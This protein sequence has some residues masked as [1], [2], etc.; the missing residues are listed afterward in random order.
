MFKEVGK[1]LG[2]LQIKNSK[3]KA[4][5]K[6][7]KEKWEKHFCEL[8]EKYLELDNKHSYS[9]L[10]NKQLS[11]ILAEIKEIAKEQIPYLNIDKAKTITEIE[12]DYAGIIYNLEQRM[13]KILQKISE[14]EVTND[15]ENN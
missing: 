4:E 10:K 7:L 11:K 15:M 3:L 14:C 13:H 2:D 5:N 6:E 12:Y 9:A 8:E 1:M